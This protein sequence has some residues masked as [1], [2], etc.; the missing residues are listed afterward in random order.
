MV[1]LYC[2]YEMG[3]T[4]PR[5]FMFVCSGQIDEPKLVKLWARKPNQIWL[6]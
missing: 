5:Y 3:Q 6:A 1:H 2:D 4:A